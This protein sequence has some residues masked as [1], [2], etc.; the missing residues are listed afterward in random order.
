MAFL[1]TLFFLVCITSYYQMNFYNNVKNASVLIQ[2]YIKNTE[3]VYSNYFSK[4]SN[5]QVWFKLE[6]HQFTGSFKVRGALHKLLTLSLEEKDRGIVAASTGNHGMAIAYASNQLGIHSEIYVP[7]NAS[8]NKIS[9]IKKLGSKI[10]YFG[11]DCLEAENQ[12]R[13]IS[14]KGNN[15]Y[16]SPYNDEYVLSGQGTIAIEIINQINSLDVIIISVGGGGLIGGVS[17]YL[18]SKWPNIHIIGCSPENSAVMIHSIASGKILNLD[19]KPT[20]SDGT[21]GGLEHDSI[22]FSICEEF[23]DETILVK[24]DEIKSAMRLYYKHENQIIEGAAGVAVA[25]L[26]KVKNKFLGKKIGVILCGGN[27]DLDLFHSIIN[28][29]EC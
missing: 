10:K 5:N 21:A 8:I 2:K 20:L 26:L 15:V 29:K 14:Y 1:F 6:N 4:I 3:L 12:A 9:K 17:K 7:D 11:H 13:K 19:S 28:K 27:I 25:T 24:E 16:V 23:I 18:K 22:T